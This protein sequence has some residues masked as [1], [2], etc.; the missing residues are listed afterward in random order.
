[1]LLQRARR[2]D[3]SGEKPLTK[4]RGEGR[5]ERIE[6][7]GGGGGVGSKGQA[8]IAAFQRCIMSCEISKTPTMLDPLVS[9]IISPSEL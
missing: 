3:A 4:K 1:M 8:D 5:W 2:N 7:T 6:G 9:A